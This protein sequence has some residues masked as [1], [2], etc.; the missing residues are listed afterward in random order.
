MTDTLTNIELQSGVWTDLNTAT[1]ISVGTAMLIQ[2]LSDEKIKIVRKTTGTPTDADGFNWMASRNLADSWVA[3]DAGEP[4]VW[5]NG[6]REAGSL[7]INVQ[8]DS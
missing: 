7:L 1:G 4:R 3:V 8:D 5:A 2:N 6:T